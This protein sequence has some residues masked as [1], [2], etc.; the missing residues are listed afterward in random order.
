MSIVSLGIEQLDAEHREILDLNVL[1]FNALNNRGPTVDTLDWSDSFC[2]KL[3]MGFIHGL[4][5]Y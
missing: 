5:K 1:L 2:V 3:C 4:K